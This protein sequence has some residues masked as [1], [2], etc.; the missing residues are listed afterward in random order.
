MMKLHEIIEDGESDKQYIITEYLQ[1]GNLAE[2]LR[3]DPKLTM[4]QI[5]TYF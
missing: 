1:L 3:K 4:D 5:R 2:R